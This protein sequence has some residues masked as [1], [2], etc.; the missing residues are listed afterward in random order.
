MSK[1]KCLGCGVDFTHPARVTTVKDSST[2]IETS[3]CPNCFDWKFDPLVEEETKL[4]F[5]ADWKQVQHSEVPLYLAE[6]GVVSHTKDLVVVAKPKM[7]SKENKDLD[8]I[9]KE[10]VEE[11]KK[12]EK[13]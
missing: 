9:F 13:L 5:Y 12:G 7:Q 11:A 1:Y 8:R 6:Y 3:V 10:G 4:E 2:T